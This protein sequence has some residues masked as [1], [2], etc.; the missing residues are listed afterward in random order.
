ME[1]YCGQGGGKVNGFVSVY[2]HSRRLPGSFPLLAQSVSL[3]CARLCPE[4]GVKPTCRLDAR[5]SQ[6]DPNRK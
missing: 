5:T 2:G 6:F 1:E 4:L 3:R